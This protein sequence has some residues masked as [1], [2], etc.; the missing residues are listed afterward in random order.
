M[1]SNINQLHEST[2]SQKRLLCIAV[3]TYN[4]ASRLD[5]ALA[6]LLTHIISSGKQ[7]DISVFVSN[8]GS[9]DS[10]KNVIQIQSDIFRNNNIVFTSMDL[11][12][13]SGFD[14]NTLN[15]YQRADADYVWFVSD[16]DNLVDDSVSTILRDVTAHS[17]AVLFYNFNQE[18]YGSNNPYIKEARLYAHLD[19]PNI[20]AIAKILHFP[21]LTSLVI[22]KLDGQA[23]NKV[24]DTCGLGFI[25]A[26]LA[27]QTALD[28]GRIFHSNKFI[29]YPDA[30]FM[31]HI[32][33]PPYIG[34]N[35]EKVVNLVLERNDRMELRTS[36][37]FESTNRL[38]TSMNTLAT[39]Y[40]GNI[41]LTPE[42]KAELYATMF[43]ELKSLQSTQLK[44]T[45]LG[46]HVLR[47]LFGYAYNI[48]SI[49]FAR[50]KATR[51]R[52]NKKV[53]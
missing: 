17:P 9:T 40:R 5:K 39:Y 43:K 32:D 42:L 25:H 11:P 12:K 47:L 51:L 2:T 38:T 49:L 35:I 13:N 23:G 26:A 53:I 29:A 3:P 28:Q 52:V 24:A 4:R 20:T 50:R 30:D 48:G 34:N 7:D 18:P 41:V 31:D 36:L 33:F 16:D 45:D 46:L 21:K 37:A 15:C 14:V 10:T 19:V 44:M 27:M 22:K 1:D 8:N 6:D